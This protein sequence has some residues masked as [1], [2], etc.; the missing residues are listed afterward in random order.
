MIGFLTPAVLA[1]S[2][3]PDTE[4]YAALT[5]PFRDA[6]NFNV[7]T[8]KGMVVDDGKLYSLNTH[9]SR[10][11]VHDL[12][13]AQAEPIAVWTTVQNPVAIAAWEGDLLVVGGATRALVR[14]SAADGRVT[15]LVELPSE[16]GDLVVDA[17]GGRAFVASQAENAVVEIDLATFT[18]TRRFDL[19][20]QRPRFLFLE[21]T[22]D[23]PAP[24]LFVAPMLSGNG[25]AHAIVPGDMTTLGSVHA[26]GQVAGIP[27]EDLYVID[28]AVGPNPP[29][30]PVATGVGT[31][32]LEHARNPSTGEYWVLAVESHNALPNQD[33]EFELR[34]IFADNQLAILPAST[35]SGSSTPS[36][37]I[38]LDDT[39]PGDPQKD[40]VPARSVSFPYALAFQD[41]ATR[42]AYGYAAI[43]SS[44][45][46]LVIL[47]EPDGD[48][49]RDQALPQGS[50]PRDLVVDH[51]G[52]ESMVHIYCWGT[53]EVRSYPL[54]QIGQPGATP[55]VRSLGDDPAPAAVRRGREIW[56]DAHRS[57]DGRTTCNTCHPDVGM[58]LLAWNLSDTPV[59]HKSLMVTQ[60]LRSIVD[61]PNYHWRGERSLQEFNGAFS[62]LLGSPSGD[63][64][65]AP[66][67]ELDDFVEFVF[68]V[69]GQANS[70]QNPDRVL[71]DALTV[72]PFE[73]TITD[74]SGTP[75]I[76]V[77]PLGNAVEGQFTFLNTPTFTTPAL[78]PILLAC[79]A[80]HSMPGGTSGHAPGDV[81]SSIPTNINFDVAHF[82]QLNHKV[83]Q[84]IV[85]VTLPSSN[86]S[87]R[88]RSGFGISHNGA[89]DS[90]FDFAAQF[91]LSAQE[92][93]SVTSFIMQFDQGIA[94]RAHAALFMRQANASQVGLAVG[95]QL[96]AQAMPS[97]RWID[98]VAFGRATVGGVSSDV[99]ML[100]DPGIDRFVLSNGWPTQSL[101]QLVALVSA[102][103]GDLV[104]LGLPPG[105]GRRFALDPDDDML[106]DVQEL[107]A[108]TDPLHPD[109]DGDGW[110]DG[111]EVANGADPT[112][113]DT[114][115]DVT[116]PSL[117]GPVVL[118][119]VQATFAKLFF[120]T[121]EPTRARVQAQVA[122]GPVHSVRSQALRRRHTIVLPRLDPSSPGAT[123][124]SYGLTVQIF[125][126]QGNSP[127]LP[128]TTFELG[129]ALSS[130][131]QTDLMP[132]VPELV[133][134]TDLAFL[135]PP[136][137]AGGGAWTFDVQFTVRREEG[138]P[139]AAPVQDRVVL[140]QVDTRI[141]E[142][143]E[144]QIADTCLVL[145]SQQLT[146]PFSVRLTPLGGGTPSDVPYTALPAPFLLPLPTNGLGQSTVQFD[147]LGL[148]GSG[149][150][151]APLASGNQVRISVLG[152]LVP[153]AGYDPAAPILTFE[154]LNNWMMP[155]TDPAFRG[156][157]FT[158]P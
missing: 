63:L 140:A 41:D 114:V 78:Q 122:G 64:D 97:T 16:P 80:C 93:A 131:F 87:F 17:A 45:G 141:S 145:S 112:S 10:I 74:P 138:A 130:S 56:Y 14:H 150:T 72:G 102:G 143:E 108:N 53:N 127:A 86:P 76:D 19:P 38:D 8:V 61:T 104:F 48:R 2:L 25:S 70:F 3:Q 156:V 34:G 24:R 62:G 89:F 54:S 101:A 65:T 28:F 151:P 139:F 30:T 42:G 33:T 132:T 21:Y 120:E 128:T 84:D 46:D 126:Q 117:V 22:G 149:C 77:S 60:S 124:N 82:R 158:I 26:P 92:S 79:G 37:L 55:V 75:V 147:V 113:V 85:P 40:Y 83:R 136:S 69:Q 4:D 134:I 52:S 81:N 94:P 47:L 57:L 100:Y 5:N 59:D 18:E 68:S 142:S 111:Y 155:S 106:S 23:P 43:A 133:T 1:L 110:E 20:V 13:S 157:T 115:T 44:T 35:G 137:P 36:E 103:V 71:D 49:F 105:D 15:A 121:D 11:V 98:V 152:V 148:N 118:E 7:E 90:L 50:I 12:A 88:A 39:T 32:L 154:S 116:A 9:G 27:D 125:D 129:G 29:P 58:D 146:G 144:W 123:P 73:R 66:G 31:L 153:V 91:T 95:A 6:T 96:I 67:G 109:S 135:S 51:S 119:H 99:R 107:A